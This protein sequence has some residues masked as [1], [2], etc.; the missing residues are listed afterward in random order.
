MAKKKR[1]KIDEKWDQGWV[2]ANVVKPRPRAK[3]FLHVR[4]RAERNLEITLDELSEAIE[5]L[6]SLAHD[7]QLPAGIS[8]QDID[9]AQA[10]IMVD[11]DK[12]DDPFTLTRHMNRLPSIATRWGMIAV[13]VDRA[14]YEI[15]KEYDRWVAEAKIG[16][17]DVLFQKSRGEGAT[18][19]NSVPTKADI[20]AYFLVLYGEDENFLSRQQMVADI[21]HVKGYIQ[22]IIK[23]IE[24][25][26]EMITNVGHMN[27][28][29][30]DKS[31]IV[32]ERKRKKK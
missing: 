3:T 19:N 12:L 20:D 2:R 28:A 24:K 25:A 22:V 16:I 13:R 21:D 11:E 7:G 32:Y 8:S 26:C 15:K 23:S 4:D 10:N 14:M 30:A 9:Q 5:G 18:A 29:M 6:T 1:T 17:R 31:L 27:R